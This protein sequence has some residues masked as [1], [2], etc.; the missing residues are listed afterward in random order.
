[1][2]QFRKVASSFDEHVTAIMYTM[3]HGYNR[4]SSLAY[5]AIQSLLE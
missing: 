2:S 1:M 3:K 5:L 4:R